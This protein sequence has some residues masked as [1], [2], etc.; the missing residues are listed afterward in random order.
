MLRS[1]Y[2]IS[3]T[4]YLPCATLNSHFDSR[5]F[6]SI[7]GG[8]FVLDALDDPLQVFPGALDIPTSAGQRLSL[9]PSLA[10]LSVLD[11]IFHTLAL[12]VQGVQVVVVEIGI[13]G[14]LPLHSGD[15]T[16]EKAL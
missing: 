2:I 14:C 1:R 15:A 16:C 3:S 13:V 12:R 11:E 6:G 9:K 7:V 4:R 10:A 8:V 5:V